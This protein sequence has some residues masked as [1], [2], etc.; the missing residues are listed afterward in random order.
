[1]HMVSLIRAQYIPEVLTFNIESE[2]KSLHKYNFEVDVLAFNETLSPLHKSVSFPK[3]RVGIARVDT[4][5][6]S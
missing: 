3:L 4:T 1:M 6:V 2:L 5:T